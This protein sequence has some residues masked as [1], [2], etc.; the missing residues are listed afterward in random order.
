MSQPAPDGGFAA[1]A[2][3]LIQLLEE[4]G[5]TLLALPQTG[6]STG[7]RSSALPVV[8]EAGEAYGWDAPPLRAPVPTA[9]RISRMDSTFAKIL[10]I[11]EDR[12]L[13]R[14]VVGC[15]ALVHPLTGRH[16]YSWRRLAQMLDTDHKSVQ[17]WHRDGIDLI[18]RALRVQAA[19]A[20]PCRMRP[21]GHHKA[22][23]APY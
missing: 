8:R 12:L 9:A 4:A 13:L 15:R 19:A 2:E 20:T 22:G 5:A 23:A 17:R 11:P 14:R 6:Y 1:E 3:A 7:L 18:L 10:L 21:Y 16:L